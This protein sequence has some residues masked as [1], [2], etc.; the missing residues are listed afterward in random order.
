MPK[1]T[2][3]ILYWKLTNKKYINF[4]YSL[5][6]TC[7][8]LWWN[9]MSNEFVFCIFYVINGDRAVPHYVHIKSVDVWTVLI[10]VKLFYISSFHC[11]QLVCYSS[12]KR[13]TFYFQSNLCHVFWNCCVCEIVCYVA[14]Q[15]PGQTTK[16]VS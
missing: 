1:K 4:S 3:I 5:G 14:E 9:R 16:L 12:N 10:L 7:G 13:S 6:N 11:C 15:K 8:Q 2:N